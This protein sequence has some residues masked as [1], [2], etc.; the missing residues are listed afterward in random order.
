VIEDLKGI[1]I[2]LASEKDGSK[3]EVEKLEDKVEELSSQ[4]KDLQAQLKKKS[5]PE[6]KKLSPDTIESLARIRNFVKH[7]GD[8]VNKAKLFE[9]GVLKEG[10]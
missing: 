3:S 4:V 1:R 5:E 2:N 7:L 8:I 10:G 9:F 6:V